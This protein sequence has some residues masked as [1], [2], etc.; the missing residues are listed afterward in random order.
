MNLLKK[1]AWGV[2]ALTLLVSGSACTSKK[3][4]WIYTSVYKEVIAE[5]EPILAQAIPD[6][7]VKWYQAGSETISSK[8]AAEIASGKP[9]ADI[10]LTSDPFFYTELKKSG[11]LLE[12]KSPAAADVPAEFSDPAG[13]YSGIR[14][15]VMVIAYHSGVYSES[16][17]PQRWKDLADPKW[18]D[19]VSMPSPLESGTAFTTVTLLSQALG[20]DYFS[21]LRTNNIVA[22]GG[23]SSVI[24]RIETKE[25]PVGI[26]LLENV[27]AAWK[28][29]SPVR[30]IYPL[31]GSVPIPSPIAILKG[32]RNPEL[33]KKV[34][35][36]LFTEP[37]TRAIVRSGLYSVLSSS[38]SPENARPW[39]EL[40]KTLLPW[41]NEILEKAYSQKDQIKAKFSEAVLH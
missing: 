28:K 29:G 23:N 34:Y 21:A 31:E 27:L 38:P 5:M 33:A 11:H 30:P 13:Q 22:A 8:L 10:L 12:Y 7:E 18:K 26:V 24:S 36:W 25:R 41:N 17:A 37:A 35:D 39:G 14:M 3:Q 1:L 20:W 32:S 2:C 6:V 16:Q 9:K 4:V 40:R 19:K 15:P